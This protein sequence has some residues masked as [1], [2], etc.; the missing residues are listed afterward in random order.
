MLHIY[1]VKKEWKE[2]HDC[3][4]SDCQVQGHEGL[5]C[6]CS[7]GGREEEHFKKGENVWRSLK[8]WWGWLVQRIVS[9]SIWLSHRSQGEERQTRMKDKT[10]V[11]VRKAEAWRSQHSLC[12][13]EA[14]LVKYHISEITDVI[15]KEEV[16]GQ[17]AARA[18]R[19]GETGWVCELGRKRWEQ[20]QERFNGR[21]DGT[22]R[23]STC[24]LRA[25][26]PQLRAPFT[27]ERLQDS[28]FL[29]CFWHMVVKYFVLNIDKSAIIF[30][31]VNVKSSEEWV[32]FST[33]HTGTR[34]GVC[35][36]R[37]C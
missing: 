25:R 30:Q 3:V 11:S 19:T 8:L 36:H 33:S 27:E 7:V 29:I 20:R 35:K 12:G 1:T 17:G 34:G 9:S 15:S 5:K 14:T 23:L 2:N 18:R 37:L 28:G 6:V 4:W 31:K 21:V 22:W 26:Q 16:V 10:S 32:P 24:T 13:Q